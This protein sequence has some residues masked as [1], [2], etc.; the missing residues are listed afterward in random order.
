ME[1]PVLSMQQGSLRAPTAEGEGKLLEVGGEIN[2][3]VFAHLKA[4]LSFGNS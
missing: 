3:N 2:K 4:D 1:N